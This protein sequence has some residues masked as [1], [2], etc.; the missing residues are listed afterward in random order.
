MPEIM[1]CALCLA[2]GLSYTIY[3]D[4]G[5]GLVTATGNL[6]EVNGEVFPT[7]DTKAYRVSGS[8]APAILNLGVRWR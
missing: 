6:E 3:T 5:N 1:Q 2:V 7:H 4:A 8:I